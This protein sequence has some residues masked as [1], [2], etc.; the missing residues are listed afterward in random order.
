VTEHAG[1]AT[2]TVAFA[3]DAA[4]IN[5]VAWA[6]VAVV[7]LCLSLLKVPDAI[8]TVMAAIGA[9]LAIF[10][11]VAYFVF[12]WST[13]GQ[14]PGNRLLSI[15]VVEAR[16][17]EPPHAG[18][19]ALRVPA[20]LLSAIP[21]CAGFLMILVDGQRRALHDRLVRTLV[22]YVREPVPA[23]SAEAAHGLVA[24]RVP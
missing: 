13:T 15:R 2:R 21:L 22:V 9:G 12:F 4:I 3:A 19:A 7:A 8:E 1:L 24:E 23:A 16:S 18:R 11:C 6:V 20:L 10:W 5:A 14:T 17:G